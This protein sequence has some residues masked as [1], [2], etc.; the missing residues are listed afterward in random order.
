MTDMFTY[1]VTFKYSPEMHPVL[2][3]EIINLLQNG[4]GHVASE[5]M[6]DPPE[7]D[8]KIVTGKHLKVTS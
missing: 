2:C 5:K 7:A 6:A 1:E 3:Y 4:W 8:P